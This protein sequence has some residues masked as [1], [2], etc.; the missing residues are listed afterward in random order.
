MIGC[1]GS[2]RQ[3]DK[4]MQ[5]SIAVTYGVADTLNLQRNIWAVEGLY[6]KRPIQCLASSEILTPPPPPHRPASVHTRWVKGVGVN[7]SPEDARHCSVL[8]V[9]KY[10]VI[11]AIELSK[12]SR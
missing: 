6:C 7:S 1:K 12:L 2:G 8:Y 3:Q 4:K 10:F 9:C 11:W 5:F